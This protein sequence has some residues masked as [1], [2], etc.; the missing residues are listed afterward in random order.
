MQHVVAIWTDGNKVCLGIKPVFFANTGNRCKVMNMNESLAYFS[1]CL[2]EVETTDN[3]AAALDCNTGITGFPTALI[4]VQHHFVH[5][6]FRV[7]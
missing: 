3:A 5:L 2:F 7:F 1:V 4:A 6:A